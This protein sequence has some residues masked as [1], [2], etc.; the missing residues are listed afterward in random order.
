MES[1]VPATICYAAV[2]VCINPGLQP[3][4]IHPSFQTYVALCCRREWGEE[5]KGVK[6]SRFYLLLREQFVHPEDPWCVDTLKWWNEYVFFPRV[7]PLRCANNLLGKYSTAPAR[8]MKIHWRPRG[9]QTARPC[10]N[11]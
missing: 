5:W 9:T 2:H 6:L 11:A 1:V 4:L 8:S 10:E 3:Y 7:S